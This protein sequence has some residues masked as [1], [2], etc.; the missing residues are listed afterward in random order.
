MHP[1]IRKTNRRITPALLL[2][3]GLLRAAPMDAAPAPCGWPIETT[4]TGASNIAYPDTDA[5]YWTMPFDSSTWSAVR[6][7]GQFPLAR[8][9]SFTAYDAQGGDATALLDAD[10]APDA[11]S[12]NPFTPAGAGTSGGTYTITLLG[13]SGAAAPNTLLLPTQVGYVLLRVYVANEGLDRQGG[14]PL[15]QI[16]LIAADESETALVACPEP[17]PGTGGTVQ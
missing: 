17:T 7:T 9:M 6:I 5:T 3:L 1:A 15:P 8:F 13:P 14:V 4:G 16:V 11:G 2:M 10:I 12:S